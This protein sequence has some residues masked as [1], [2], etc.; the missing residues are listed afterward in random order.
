MH[1]PGSPFVNYAAQTPG[2]PRQCF[3]PSATWHDHESNT[4]Q[5]HELR[6][7]T[8][9][10]WRMRGDRRLVLGELHASTSSA[11]WLYKSAEPGLHSPLVPPPG[12]TCQQ[13]RMCANDNIAFFDDITRGYK[14]K[15]A[16][17]SVDVDMIPKTLT[18]TVG[19]R[20]YNI[21]DFETGSDVGSFGCES[22]GLYTGV[23]CAGPLSRRPTAPR[24]SMR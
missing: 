6:L 21:D 23:T 13:S 17:G 16:F 14:Q 1:M 22:G 19:T 20:Y 5:S 8:P 15:A 11:D 9:D 2:N 4:H 3:S 24:T 10:D 7:S 18:L 12:A